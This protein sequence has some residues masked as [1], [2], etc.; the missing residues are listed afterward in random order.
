MIKRRTRP[1][2]RRRD[3]EED[4]TPDAQDDLEEDEEDVK[5]S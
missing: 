1:N 4:V 3:P 2:A 5:L